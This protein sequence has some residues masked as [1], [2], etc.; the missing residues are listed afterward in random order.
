MARQ[1]IVCG[2]RLLAEEEKAGVCEYCED[3]PDYLDQKRRASLPAP[4]PPRDRIRKRGGPEWAAFRTGLVLL[5][6]VV[7]ATHAVSLGG[8]FLQF[9]F[10]YRDSLIF[11]PMLTLARL[12]TAL[13]ALLAFGFFC[14]VPG[15]SKLPG[16]AWTLMI[17]ALGVL[18]TLAVGL[19]LSLMDESGFENGP[20]GATRSG[21]VEAFLGVCLVAVLILGAYI[22]LAA[23]LSGAASHLGDARLAGQFTLFFVLVL[24]TPLALVAL[25][26]ALAHMSP[27]EYELALLV[28]MGGSCGLLLLD[29]LFTVWFTL[30]LV[31]LRTLTR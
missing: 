28:N 4:T 25:W 2:A 18:G 9:L 6:V 24:L 21:D 22:C 31:R 13:L 1:C 8:L 12:M 14:A 10:G 7:F 27:Y 17:C 26:V 23:L 16:T 3:D 19:A 30:L 20:F 29:L 11:S 5:L 15:S